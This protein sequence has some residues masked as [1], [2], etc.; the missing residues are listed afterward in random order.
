MNMAPGEGE[1]G[2]CTVSDKPT[3]T[4]VSI[5]VR[6]GNFSN[7]RA[8][9]LQPNILSSHDAPSRN[10]LDSVLLGYDNV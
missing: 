8:L 2:R 9:K 5:I 10:C 6:K 3:R 1:D 4:L 7:F